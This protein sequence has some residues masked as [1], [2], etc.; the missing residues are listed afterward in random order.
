MRNEVHSKSASSTR[1]GRRGLSRLIDV[2]TPKLRIP[3][4]LINASILAVRHDEI[5]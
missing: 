4:R 2:G 5:I 3:I 1:H